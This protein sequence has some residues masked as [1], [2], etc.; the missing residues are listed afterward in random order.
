MTVS[1]VIPCYKQAHLLPKAVQSVIVQTH[2]DTEIIVVDDSSPDDVAA[3]LAPF[4]NRVK[5]I[6]RP[7]GGPNAARNTGLAAATG[8]ACLFLDADDWLARDALEQHL[9]VRTATHADVTVSGWREVAPD[10]RTVYER[11]T[12]TVPADVFHSL[13]R[14]NMAVCHCFLI[15]RS[16]LQ[17][18]GRFNEA[19]RYSEDWEMWIKLAAAE[20]KFAAV[21]G[22]LAYYLRYP[23]SASTGIERMYDST[24]AM[25]ERWSRH[26][27]GCAD[28][29]DAAA[30][31]MAAWDDNYFRNDISPSLASARD[32]CEFIAVLRRAMVRVRRRPQLLGELLKAIG[33]AVRA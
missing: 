29:R 32:W 2:A 27:P 21:P 9:A 31:G 7:N 16:A 5:L 10:G 4:G 33:R 18:V 30:A 20:Y 6:R 11:A 15:S 8:D 1:V 14:E 26:H 13:L 28:C 3:A 19:S 24:I 22:A 17:A 25:L 12:P 23:G